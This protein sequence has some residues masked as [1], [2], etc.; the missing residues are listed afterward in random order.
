MLNILQKRRNS[1]DDWQA[2]ESDEWQPSTPIRSSARL[3][4]PRRAS[5]LSPTKSYIDPTDCDTFD[6]KEEIHADDSK[7]E[8]LCERVS[9]SE[10]RTIEQSD[11]SALRAGVSLG[12]VR[13]SEHTER[14]GKNLGETRSSEQ[15]YIKDE[16][17]DKGY[18]K[19]GKICDENGVNKQSETA[20]G[21]ST[22]TLKDSEPMSNNL[23]GT[24]RDV[25]V[26]RHLS[27]QTSLLEKEL[28]NTQQQNR[29]L[30]HCLQESQKNVTS[31]Q[32]QLAE[33]DI[34]LSQL[35]EDFFDLK[36]RFEKLSKQ[37]TVAIAGTLQSN[38]NNNEST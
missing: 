33:R 36:Q 7:G 31:L 19:C 38:I 1:A 26:H 16:P 2:D 5:S 34:L 11:S 30:S 32:G 6:I 3:H 35:A 17:V 37:F 12:E 24:L 23:I 10:V 27:S 28:Q 25:A 9:V 18:E 4:R 13:S 8:G 22:R 15:V 20:T 21:N 14:V 29:H